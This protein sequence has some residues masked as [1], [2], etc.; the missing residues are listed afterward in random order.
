MTSPAIPHGAAP[1]ADRLHAFEAKLQAALALHQA[2]KADAA[3]AAYLELVRMQPA[4]AAPLLPLAMLALQ[5]GRPARALA[6]AQGVLTLRPAWREA[7]P[8]L[9]EAARLIGR[10]RLSIAGGRR[11]LGLGVAD[12]AVLLSLGY[13]LVAE[14][15]YREALAALDRATELRRG[16][17][18]SGEA[19][20]LEDR[21]FSRHAKLR[22]DLQQFE[23]LGSLGLI[24]PELEPR[25]A[26]LRAILEARLA[27]DPVGPMFAL[28]EAEQ[29]R[30]GETYNRLVFRRGSARVEPSAL[31]PALDPT[32]IEADYQG[33]EPGIT[34]IDGLL[35]PA[36]LEELYRY[37]V[38]STFWFDYRH[39]GGYVGAYMNEGFASQLLFQIAGE[40]A[41]LLPGIFRGAKLTEMWAYKYDATG[42]GIE[43]HADSAAVNVNFWV[44]PDDANLD[45][46]RGGLEIWN[47][48]A[49]ADWNFERYNNDQAAIRAYLNASG[50]QS[51]RVPYRRNRAVVFN[52]DLFHRT[53]DYRFR[54]AYAD[55]RINV[56]ML[57]GIRA[58][59]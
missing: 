51:V 42:S 50:A 6:L 52:S 12:S 19:G 38:Q 47:R 40:L 33:R 8:F 1:A 43:L 35:R 29:D 11:A 22:H 37:C 15:R 5:T 13:A 18:A 56:T 36:A 27:S 21:M 32:A 55:R 41:S 3:E 17:A 28:T 39:A 14:G 2:G 57:F 54:D 30:L 46:E 49:P 48:E 44:T 9:A 26:A 23:L 59:S 58:P 20:R 45:P 16:L 53:D 4:E 25:I 24:G 34:W 7:W 31:S 10:Y